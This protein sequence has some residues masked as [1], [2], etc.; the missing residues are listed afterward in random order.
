MKIYATSIDENQNRIEIGEWEF[1]ESIDLEQLTIETPE[2]SIG[3]TSIV[4]IQATKMLN[5]PDINLNAL[6]NA[7]GIFSGY[8]S[9]KE[10]VNSIIMIRL[11]SG[12]WLEITLAC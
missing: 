5:S 10:N 12:I 2:L 9:L 7:T 6:E 8:L 11:S 3:D 4:I 1:T